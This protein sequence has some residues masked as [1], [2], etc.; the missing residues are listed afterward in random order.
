MISQYGNLFVRS[1]FP[2]VP[3]DNPPLLKTNPVQRTEKR[4]LR[5]I[6]IAP[7]AK[8]PT[9]EWP[10]EKME[11]VVEHLAQSRKYRIY[12]FGGGTLERIILRNWEQLYPNTKFAAGSSDF[13]QELDLMA[14]LDLFLS[15]DSANMHFASVL[16]VPVLSIWGGTHPFAG[17]YG[18]KQDPNRA[19]QIEMACRPCSVFG[20]KP[21]R[22]GTLACLH[23]ISVEHIL[24]RIENFFA[25]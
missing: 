25:E 7:F 21:C 1:G 14:N 12:L 20:S 16:G 19:I 22:F 10:V 3:L 8:H 13:A 4:A 5:H 15:M 24:Q 6:G 9:K 2:P 18:W 11:K 17:F 23:A